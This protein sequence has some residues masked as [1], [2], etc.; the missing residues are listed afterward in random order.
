MIVQVPA[1]TRRTDRDAPVPVRWQI[2]EL[3][4]V[5]LI[6]KPVPLATTRI[7]KVTPTLFGVF[8]NGGANLIVGASQTL[9]TGSNA[10]RYVLAFAEISGSTS[11]RFVLVAPFRPGNSTAFGDPPLTSK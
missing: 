9:S 10:S 7:G 2:V 8:G 4:G 1:A 6:V 5:V 11:F 3:S